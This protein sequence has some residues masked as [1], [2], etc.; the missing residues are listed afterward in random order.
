[1]STSNHANVEV[2]SGDGLDVRSF[3]VRQGMSELFHIDVRVRSKNHD[4]D[5][6]AIIGQPAME[7][8]AL[9][10]PIVSPRLLS[11][12]TYKRWTVEVKGLNEFPRSEW[13]DNIPLL[14]Y[15]YRIMVGL[16][17]FFILILCGAAF[18]WWRG[19]LFRSRW[20]LW[21][22]MLAVPFPYIANTAGWITAEVGRQP[23]LVYGLY[24][25]ADGYSRNVSS[26]NAMFTLIGF[27]GMY[28][29][30][31]ILV[32]FLVRREIDHGPGGEAGRAQV[33]P[34][35]RTA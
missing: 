16:G 32:L 17:T 12:L 22:L 11:F 2:A 14:Y 21:I 33:P 25:T 30:L 26:G 23:W 31:A 10:N 35:P 4:V 7:R 3:A 24:R 8:Q 27:T 13:P 1:M 20:M 34:A 18:L 5:F 29:V 6:D 28:T 15:S 19:R 9:D